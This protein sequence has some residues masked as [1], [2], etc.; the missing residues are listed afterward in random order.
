M[1]RSP[2]SCD[3]V[4]ATAKPGGGVRWITNLGPDRDRLY[5]HLVA[6]LVP[7]IERSLGPGVMA[8]RARDVASWLVSPRIARRRWRAAVA[9]ALAPGAFA[10]LSDVRDC[11]GSIGLPAVRAG[12]ARAG[13][14]CPEDLEAFLRAAALRGLPVGPEPSAVLA[15]AVLAIADDAAAATG[16]VIVRWVDDVVIAG[17]D[18]AAARAGFE[19]WRSALAGLRLAPN[20]TKTRS[21]AGAVGA[22]RRV[23]GSGASGAGGAVRG[24]IRWP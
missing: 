22:G 14:A 11:Y 18:R 6:P 1:A 10:I 5:R 4:E 8:N 21:V 24:I 12:L 17:P 15:N 16:V 7:R 19:A 23:P 13:S 20:E 3:R 2:S 9:A